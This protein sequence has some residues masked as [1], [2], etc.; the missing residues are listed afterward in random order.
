MNEPKP[1]QNPAEAHAYLRKR[2]PIWAVEL[3]NYNLNSSSLG[4]SGHGAFLGLMSAVQ[5]ECNLILAAP[6]IADPLWADYCEAVRKTWTAARPWSPPAWD[7]NP[8]SEATLRAACGATAAAVRVICAL[9]DQ[10]E[11]VTAAG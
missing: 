2:L 3:R 11:P 7:Q 4:S 5:F 6:P 10:L 9:S 8:P 1:P